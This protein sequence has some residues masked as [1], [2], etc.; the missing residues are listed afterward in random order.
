MKSALLFIC[1]VTVCL[2]IML[3][4]LWS[5]LYACG[6]KLFIIFLFV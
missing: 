3:F 5:H 6:F 4:Y 1:I 2:I